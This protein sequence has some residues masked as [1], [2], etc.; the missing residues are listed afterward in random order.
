VCRYEITLASCAMSI[1][2]AALS[3]ITTR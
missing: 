3:S 1:R 2:V